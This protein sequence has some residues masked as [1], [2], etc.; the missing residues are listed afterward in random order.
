MQCFDLAVF[1]FHIRAAQCVASNDNRL[2]EP[3]AD[4]VCAHLL[5]AVPMS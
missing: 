3:S 5:V 1:A 2:F 4:D